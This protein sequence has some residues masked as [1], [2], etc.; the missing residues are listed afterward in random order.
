MSGRFIPFNRTSPDP[1]WRG[2]GIYPY[3]L[4]FSQRCGLNAVETGSRVLADRPLH[5]RALFEARTEQVVWVSQE[6]CREVE[7]PF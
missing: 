5:P 2:R 4:L 7:A 6:T 1:T 3:S